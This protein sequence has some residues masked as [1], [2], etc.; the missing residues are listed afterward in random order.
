VERSRPGL[1]IKNHYIRGDAHLLI[2]E[3]SKPIFH[4]FVTLREAE[5]YIAEKGVKKYE[6]IIKDDTGE[7]TP[8]K[9]QMAYYAVANG[10][11]PEIQTYY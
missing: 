9:G 7:T 8:R 4:G 6:R 10:R 3:F 11:N 2:T 5:V 1:L